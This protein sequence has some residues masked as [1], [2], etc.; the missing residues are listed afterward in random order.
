MVP[1]SQSGRSVTVYDG[2]GRR[3]AVTNARN[4]TTTYSYDPVGRMESETD[5]L[6]GTV[7]FGYDLAGQHV[8]VADPNGATR[9]FGFDD[10]G[11]TTTATDA[12]G[13]ATTYG[14]DA[15]GRQVQMTDARGIVVNSVFDAAGQLAG[16]TSPNETRSYA[17]DGAGRMTEWT[18]ITGTT[19]QSFDDAGRVTEVAA[20]AGTVG[21]SYNAAGERIGMSQP[22]GSVAYT[23]DVNGY[24]A[25][26]TD[27]RNETITVANDPDGR[28]AGLSRSNGVDSVHSFDNAGRLV[29]I[30]HT[31]PAGL[32]DSFGYTL[33]GNGNRTQV[34]STA[35]TE[36]YT[37][38][39]LN[40]LTG[41]SYPD[42]T[43]EV[44]GYDPASNRT[45][46]TRV[47]GATVGYTVD[48]VGQLVSDTDGVAYSYDAAGNLTG[49]SAG[50]SYT[51]DDYGRMVAA[52]A[53]GVSQTYV[54]D[55]AGVRTAVDG[56]PQVWDGHKQL[57]LNVQSSHSGA[58]RLQNN[59]LQ[60]N[61]VFLLCK[62]IF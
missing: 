62:L 1:S 46:H 11:R 7:T 59:Y 19:T 32:I 23:Y 22:E 49:T 39:E 42:A 60:Y 14:Y 29:E 17:Y 44:F 26:V 54:Y 55:A 56:Q 53:N 36:S 37:L 50:D 9:M 3:T 43:V 25:T 47:D 5:P 6:G 12:L 33:D 35:G 28:V 20:P 41:V 40:R 38:D 8:S 24:Q 13:R 45:S 51:F 21:Y 10:G 48:A 61:V 52:T 4:N 18:D 34:T 30:A 57:L 2:A 16:Q 15:V 31:G 58:P 27:W